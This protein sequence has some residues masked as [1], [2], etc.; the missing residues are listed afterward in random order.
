MAMPRAIFLLAA[1]T[2]TAATLEHLTLDQMASKS[3]AVVRARVKSSSSALRGSMVYTMVHV[4]VLERWKGASAGALSVAIPGGEAAGVRQTF[5]GAPR[6]AQGGE[7]V[8]F[9]WAGRNGLVQVIGLSQGVFEVQRHGAA[10][11]AFRGASSETIL[12]ARGHPVRDETIR[13]GL[14]E[15]KALVRKVVAE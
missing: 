7:Y 4:E 5:S 3:T 8:L 13:I 1:A 12:D 2:L 15:L 11:F 6:L 10:L 9:L 14:A